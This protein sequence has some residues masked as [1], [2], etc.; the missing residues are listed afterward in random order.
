M[1][2]EGVAPWLVLLST[3]L[4]VS[5]ACARDGTTAPH[6]FQAGQVWTYETRPGE[7]ISRLV[8]CKVEPDTKLGKIVH[9]QVAGVAVKS[10][11]SPGG[12]SGIVGHMPISEESLR[13]SVLTLEATSKDLP[14]YKEGYQIWQEAFDKGEASVFEISVAQGLNF[15]ED[16][17][18]R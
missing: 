16:V 4:A 9:I 15:M 14:E 11:D 2:K 8:V 3:L 5:A 1:N 7:E 17:L 6:A 12:V 13:A 10:P 18:N